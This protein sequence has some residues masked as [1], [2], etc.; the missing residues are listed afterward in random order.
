MDVR[1]TLALLLTAVFCSGA[2]TFSALMPAPELDPL[3][4]LGPLGGFDAPLSEEP[5]MML[6][7]QQQA[8]AAMIELQA[9]HGAHTD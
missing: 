1:R 5:A 8:L 9:A 3:A 7:L 6:P 2:L 4:P